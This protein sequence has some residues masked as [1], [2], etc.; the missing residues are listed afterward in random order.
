MEA[1]RQRSGLKG[2]E[3]RVEK[4]QDG[5]GRQR[6][7]ENEEERGLDE[8]STS[9]AVRG[10]QHNS[11]I[12][13]VWHGTCERT[14]VWKS[15][16]CVWR[17]LIGAGQCGV[18]GCFSCIMRSKGLIADQKCTTHCFCSTPLCVHQY[19]VCRHLYTPIYIHAY[20]Q[21]CRQ[22]SYIHIYMYIHMHARMLHIHIYAYMHTY[23]QTYM[24]TYIQTYR[25]TDRQTYLQIY[26]HTYICIRIDMSTHTY[27]QTHAH[28]HTYI[29]THTNWILSDTDHAF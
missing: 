11:D 26:T 28:I 5:E 13:G 4:E 3:K 25:H 21:A 23:I 20:L 7:V 12:L 14:F 17:F 6:R 18:C 27:I 2:K 22:H 15:V 1:D 16:L 10:V 9:R 24:H 19:I 8:S 29:R